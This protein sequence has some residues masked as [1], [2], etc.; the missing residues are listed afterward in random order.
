LKK[1]FIGSIAVQVIKNLAN[2]TI[3]IPK[4][5]LKFSPKKI[6]VAVNDKYP[7]NILALNNF[8]DFIGEG[9]ENITF[10]YMAKAVE[11]NA[12]VQK[13]LKNLSIIYSEKFNTTFTVY[14]ENSFF[15][16][17]KTLIN[18][19]IEE[20]LVVQKGSRFLTDQIFRKFMINELI[21]DGQTPLVVLP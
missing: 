19:K 9:I 16:I 7:T 11:N 21:Y 15:G 13:Q 14:E 3:A 8:L 12:V 17:I 5:V 10:F 6:F 1:I 18:S 20:L 4:D 2:T